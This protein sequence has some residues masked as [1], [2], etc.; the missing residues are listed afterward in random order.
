MEFSEDVVKVW[1]GIVILN[2]NSTAINFEH[3]KEFQNIVVGGQ[4]Q[5]FFSGEE[6]GSHQDATCKATKHVLRTGIQHEPMS[7]WCVDQHDLKYQTR[8]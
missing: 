2:Y 3:Q 6:R 1:S 4:C 5:F 7:R 8:L